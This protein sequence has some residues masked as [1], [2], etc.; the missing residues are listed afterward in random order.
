MTQLALENL[1]EQLAKLVH[2]AQSG[3][4]IMFTENDKPA[5]R[6][7]PVENIRKGRK[8]GSARHLPHFMAEDF[9]ATPEGFE[10][11]MP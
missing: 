10:E 4:K 1:S 7:V 8:T 5:A 11:Y 6:L 2:D 3:E 9:D